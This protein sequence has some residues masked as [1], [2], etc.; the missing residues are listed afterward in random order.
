MSGKPFVH[1]HLHT[2]YSLLDGACRI[3]DLVDR[4]IE[5]GMPAVAMTDH[6]NLFGAV[7]FYKTATARGIKPILGCEV[8]MA[9]TSRFDRRNVGIRDSA[10]H[11]V[12]LAKG[13]EG[14]DN[15]VRL[16]SLGH[17]EGFYYRP[18]IDRELLGRFSK[19]LIG[20]SACLKGEIACAILR[21]EEDTARRLVEEYS[22][23]FAPGDFYL[24]LMNHGIEDQAKVN[25]ALIRLG[26]ELGVPL[27]ATNDVHYLLREHAEA[28]DLLLCIQTQ[29]A[30]GDRDRMR[31][32]GDFHL[33]SAE[34]M[35]AKFPETPEA[36]E[37]AAEIAEKCNV[38]MKFGEI[39][40]PVYAPETGEDGETLLRRLTFEGAKRRFGIDPRTDSGDERVREIR[41]RL[42]LE[43]KIISQTGFVSYFLVVWDF[44]RF[45]REQHIPIG[46]GRGSGAGSLV[47]Y[48]L[49]I[50]NID[51]LRYGLLF[52]RFLN[53]E[54]VSPPDF[55]IDLCY[56][57]RGEV[58]QYVRSKYGEENVAQIITFGTLGAKSAV[59]D[60]ARALGLPFKEGDR[61]AKMIPDELNI[62][63]ERALDIG[64]ELRKA[65]ENEAVTRQ[66]ID[67]ARTLEGLPRNA[68]THAA[69]VVIG[70]RP[71]VEMVPL[72]RGTGDE[73]VTQFSMKALG[74]L[75]LLKMDF[76]GLKTLT[77]ISDAV[78][79]IEETLGERIDIDAVPL[80]DPKTFD[81]I[82][83]A[84]TVGVFQ[85]ES[86]GMRDLSRRIG[87][88]RFEDIIALI[89][90]F[91][92]GPM[93]MLDDFVQRKHGKIEVRYDHPLL[94]PI[95][96]ETYGVMLYQEQV[97]QVANVL[98]GYSLGQADILRRAMSKKNAREMESQR[99]TFID[100][101]IERGIEARTAERIF[102]TLAR[103]AEYGF[104]KSH[105]AAYAMVCYQ[106]AWL[107]A[108]YPVQFL[109]A[110]MSNEMGNT[111]KI[112]G[113]VAEAKRMGIEVLPPDVNRCS[114]KFTVHEGR[115]RF[116][117]GAVKNLGTHAVDAVVA[118]RDEGGD[119]RS[120]FDF[121]A[122]VDSRVVNRKAIESLIR[123]GAFDSLGHRRSQLYAVIDRA[124]AHGAAVQRDRDRGQGMLFGGP[125]D[126]A[127]EEIENELPDVP[128]WEP[129]DLL[130]GER[131]LLGIY[132]TGHPL[133]EYEDLI[134]E[135]GLTSISSLGE[136]SEGT[137]V[138][139]GGILASIK[140]RPIR[141]RK[142]R[143][144]IL[145]L[146]DLTGSVKVLVFS[147]ALPRCEPNLVDDAAVLVI[148]T[149]DLKEE[150]P[151]IR[152]EEVIPLADA[153]KRLT[154][155]LV[156]RLDPGKMPELA[157]LRA[158]LGRHPGDCPV[159]FQLRLQDRGEAWV[160]VAD[161]FGVTVDQ[162]LFEEL[163]E[164][165]GRGA[166]R[167]LAGG[168]G[169]G[170][171]RN[172]RIRR[173]RN[174]ERR[175]RANAG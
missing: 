85:L 91:R 46:P 27:V 109:A 129:R 30:V 90:L 132:V 111:D 74:D 23:F 31:Y 37:L 119:F 58:I 93:K 122:R 142:E 87:V 7:E 52:E 125:D 94:E 82:N 86:A 145:R 25:A 17:L 136:L 65:Y 108:H 103:F 170:R 156:V 79:L 150:E 39:R 57:R 131:E 167:V 89:A 49:G 28:H 106:T 62:S 110:L 115:I 141:N 21:D 16:V 4:A 56:D 138:R 114:R 12:L 97:M 41:D 128:E 36:V 8:Y 162:D 158:I 174:G 9:P 161:R 1:L 40:Y 96:K 2:Q 34:E 43:L 151:S 102:D 80:D 60:V 35:Y 147:S 84:E 164:E 3:G 143:M 75:G 77:V 117:L 50:T 29:K 64:E 130:A 134:R 24:E 165:I 116:G 133:T 19:G 51:P 160:Q 172:G 99:R 13:L 146:E 120:L 175:T 38:E 112:Q 15:L 47:A 14:Y 104:N 100:G 68:S 173:A 73:V 69:G 5:L 18:R 55:D 22:S 92:P 6:G 71:L 169:N 10:Y 139:I 83:R 135:Y 107:K 113:L 26:R 118:A 163:E 78:R 95:L 152:A 20:M 168:N 154:R 61:I 101:C 126:S 149:V 53:P 157:R 98:A 123:V 166:V 11:L 81:L 171:N 88:E 63:L 70:A 159:I 32:T 127:G 48:C 33:R 153:R 105:S 144:A 121:C 72:S 140:T 148:G 59:R 76:L 67:F 137:E 66:V 45:A 54:R 155:K 42:E 124:I 44:I